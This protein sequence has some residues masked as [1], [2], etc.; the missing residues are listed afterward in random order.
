MAA[1]NAT[2]SERIARIVVRFVTRPAKA[3]TTTRQSLVLEDEVVVRTV[4]PQTDNPV[5]TCA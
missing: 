4:D 1:V 2:T 3:T 5:P